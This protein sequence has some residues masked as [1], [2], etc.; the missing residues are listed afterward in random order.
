MVPYFSANFH[1]EGRL[2]CLKEN[3]SRLFADHFS[4]S[5]GSREMDPD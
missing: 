4:N 3:P 2:V 1:I 5:A